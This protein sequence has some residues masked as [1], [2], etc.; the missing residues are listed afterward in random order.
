MAR[1][2]HNGFAMRRALRRGFTLVELMVVV[3]I[4]GVLAALAIYGLR[5][6]QLS[7]GSGEGTAMLQNIRGAEEAWRAENLSYG[8]CDSTSAGPRNDSSITATEMYPRQISALTDQKIQWG[9]ITTNVGRCFQAL[10]VRADGPV[11]FSYGIASGPPGADGDVTEP[12]AFTRPIPVFTAP[13]EPWYAAVAV[14]DLDGDSA[15]SGPFTRMSVHS[16]ATEVYVEDE[17]E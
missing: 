6:Y 5:K 14:A 16:R 9:L 8:G 15:G 3:A 4:V 2:M 17:G 12:V 13:R 1:R 10:G 11:K 7:A